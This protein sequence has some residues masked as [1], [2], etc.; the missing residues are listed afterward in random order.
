[1]DFTFTPEQDELRQQARA[2]LAGHPEAT[3]SELAELGWTGV[4]IPEEHGGAGL[5]F[6]EEAVLFEELGRALYRGPYLSTIALDAAGAARRSAR[7]GGCGRS[8]LDARARPS[9]LG[10]R[11]R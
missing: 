2:F 11:H 3:W 6:L 8:E 10:S 4:S 9:R 1:M 5:T 7:R